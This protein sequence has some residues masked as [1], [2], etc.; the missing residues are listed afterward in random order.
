MPPSS[1]TLIPLPLPPPIRVISIL[2]PKRITMTQA[3]RRIRS[4]VFAATN[5]HP[6]STPSHLRPLSAQALV[7][8]NDS[9]TC[10]TWNKPLA[11]IPFFQYTVSI[12][13]MSTST[14]LPEHSILLNPTQEVT[15]EN[16][17]DETI[18]CGNCGEMIPLTATKCP[19]CGI[20]L[21]DQIDMPDTAAPGKPAPKPVQPVSRPENVRR[22]PQTSPAH[23]P[24][25]D[26]DV[27][28]IAQPV[29]I[30]DFNMPFWSMVALMIK[31]ALASIPALLILAVISAIFW[32]IFPAIFTFFI[33]AF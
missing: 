24:L 1:L 10:H 16:H 33:Q 7:F 26:D 30:V 20:N 25:T 27:Y 21:F 22:A 29:F 18:E 11:S 9:Q 6:M 15:M 17:T 23:Q 13:R 32:V 5:T 4:F 31:I 14:P 19:M 2:T 8:T 12:R 28:E 3:N